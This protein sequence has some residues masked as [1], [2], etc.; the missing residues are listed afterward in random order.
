MDNGIIGY[1]RTA[2]VIEYENQCVLKLF[3]DFMNIEFINDEFNIAMHAFN[4]RLPTPKPISIIKQNNKTGIVYEKISGD[5]LLL[6]LSRNPLSMKKIVKKMAALHDR[7][8]A[9]SYKNTG[10]GQKDKIRQAI[11]Q[12]SGLH[13]NDKEKI[14]HYLNS[15]PDGHFL[16]H[17]DF[18]P[19]NIIMNDDGLWIIDWMTGSSGNPACDAARTKM[20]FECSDIPDSVSFIMKRVLKYAQ[21]KAAD[22]YIKEYCKLGKV[23]I[24]EIN[25]WLLPLYAARLTE[26]LSVNEKKLLQNKIKR[27]LK[28]I[29]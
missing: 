23:K 27:E 18:H 20:I 4:N 22:A 2:D 6:E 9:H 19:D 13:D 17:G 28:R 10:N 21:K 29:P 7:I 8:H 11:A 16:C 15:L 12:S 5:S 1:G 3:K 14:I 25:R 24:K 26:N